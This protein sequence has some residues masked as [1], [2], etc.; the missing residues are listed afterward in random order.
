MSNPN[1]YTVGWICAITTEYVSAQAFLDEKHDGPEY[2]S[3]NDNNDYTLGKIGKHNTVIAVLPNREYGTSSAARVASRMLLSFPSVRIGLMVGIGGGAPSRKHD[4]RLGDIVVSATRDG[5]GGVFQYDFGKTIQGQGFQTTAFLNQPPEILRTAMSGLMAQYEFEGHQLDEAINNIL[6]KRQRLRKKYKRPDPSSDRLYQST[7]VHPAENETTCIAVCGNDP[8][9]LISR[10]ERAEEED[11]P[12]IHYGLIASANQLMKDALVRDRF[13]AEN[14]VL[15]FEMEAAGLMNHFPCL[16]I[17]G[18]CDY[19]DS[20]KN[21]EWQG[22]AA[23]AA[24]AYAKDLL[25]RIAPNKVEAERKISDVLSSVERDLNE[26]R[27]AIKSTSSAI[28]QGKVDSWL[29][30]PD[31]SANYNKA[32]QQ[33]QKGSGLWFLQTDTFAKWNKRQNSFLWLHGIPGCGKTILSSTIIEELERTVP[34]QS[35]LYFYFD[36]SEERK[37]TLES[38]VRSL[39]SQLYYKH[40]QTAQQLDSL[41]SSCGNGRRQPTSE[42][43]GKVLLHNIEQVKEVWIVLDALDECRTR[44][45]PPTEG[46]LSW[47][48]EVL[49][50]EQRNVHL[51]VT[52]RLEQDIESGVMEFALNDDIV[53]IQSSVI[54]DD[55]RAYVKT[56]VR[57]DNPLKRW[58]NRPDV[59]QEIETRLMEKVGGMFRWAACQLDALENCLDYRALKTALASLPK[60]LDETYARILHGIPHEHKQNAT[61]ILQFLMCS[62]RP[63]R[64]EEAVDAIAVDTEGDQYFD[65]N[66]RMPDPRE[67]SCY[68]SSLVVVVSAKDHSHDKGDMRMELRLAHFS[69]K[70]YLTSN[71]LQEGIAQDFQAVTTKASIA[72]VCLAYL[73][74]LN[75]NIPIEK[76]RKTFPLA[77]YSA[78]YWVDHAAIA[79]GKDRILQGFVEKLFCHYKNSYRNC[80]SLYQPDR[81]WDSEPKEPASALYYAS[82]GGLVNAVKYLLSQGADVNA[83]GGYYGNALHAASDKGHEKIVELLV[84][85]GANVN[86]QGGP[87]SGNAL[88]AASHGGH[89]KIVELLIKVGTDVNAQGGGYGNALQAASEGGHEKIVELLVKAGANVNAQS[90]GYSG[91]ALHAASEGGHE[92]IVELLVKAGAN[93]NAQGRSYSGN[94]LHAASEGGHKKIVE[95][96]VKAGANVNAQS[97]DYS[98]ALYTASDRGYKKIVELLV[99]A[100]AD[101]NAQGGYYGNALYATSDKGHEKIVELLVKAGANVN[102][103]SGPYSSNALQAASD[104]GHEKIVELLVKAGAD[105]NAQ[106]RGYRGNA[107]HAASH[108]GHEKIV[109]LLVKAGADVNA[110]SGHYGNALHAT[111][112]GGHEKIVEL[113]VKA[114]ANVNAQG[115]GYSSNALHTAS[116]RGYEKIVELLVKA[117]ANVNAQ[118]GH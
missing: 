100:G 49:H 116:G 76:I 30:P 84:K 5:K 75:Q 73:L 74:H 15:C 16:V 13:A 41:F 35:L 7:V 106:G 17:R 26:M 1:D 87:Y 70:E 78:R 72:T 14:D 46:L 114:G 43:L 103:Q 92:K 33:R 8:S 77:Q 82:F 59:Q 3:P 38:M 118:G 34:C 39:V 115:R 55:I 45:G 31:P 89:E 58:R 50:S 102:A 60:T 9:Q 37:Q 28:K 107:L 104:R 57:E 79:E 56:R 68:C 42:S 97:G 10:P 52:S 23:M 40:E 101:V 18:I 85:A 32:L 6:E 80:Y 96:L 24:A 98:N 66:Y 69:V 47:I 81:P 71:R 62:E 20:H 86:A 117:G 94:A 54:T 25:R 29:S 19:S 112:D 105:V 91:N 12:A 108:R 44:K 83:Q 88:H 65:P 63:L 90:G 51:L 61:R 48:R 4:I 111:L 113:L 36:F 11:N 67:I 93:V 64:I 27:V 109:E 110:Q 21:K 53:P 2:V 95:L 22:Y 99:K